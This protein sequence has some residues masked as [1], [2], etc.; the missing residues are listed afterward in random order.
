MA[1]S[2][3]CSKCG[4]LVDLKRHCHNVYRFF[5]FSNPFDE[6]SHTA[7]WFQVASG[8]TDVKYISDLHDKHSIWCGP[9][10]DYE[11]AKSD[12]HSRL[13][14]ELTR[15]NFIWGGLECFYDDLELPNCPKYSGKINSINYFL[16][17]EY[18]SEVTPLK[19]YKEVV[20]LVSNL[21]SQNPWYGK[22]DDL[23]QPNECTDPTLIGL[24]VVYKIRNLFAHGA[25]K[26]SEPS[27]WN[28]ITPHDISIIAASSRITLLTIQMLLR[29]IGY[30]L[31]F[32]I[33]QLGEVP[34]GERNSTNA[35]NFLEYMHLKDFSFS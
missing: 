22:R 15:F 4:P 29:I 35:G 6:V 16:K 13:I 24:K 26:F 10:I 32:P 27:E 25:F 30:D 19:Y 23:F 12:F 21:V 9:A 31:N 17:T 5:L 11:E 2:I 3:I 14:L 20:D 1:H 18:A 34:E 28:S 33:A 8:I 7:T